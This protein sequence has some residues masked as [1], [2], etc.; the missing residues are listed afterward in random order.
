MTDAFLKFLDQN[1]EPFFA[2]MFYDASHQPYWYPPEHAVF[3]VGG[4]TEDINYLKLPHD[5]AGMAFIKNRYKNSLHYVDAELGRVLT[6]LQDRGLATNTLVFV[7]GDHGEEFRECGLFGHDSSFSPWQTKTLMVA[8]IPGE[9]P[10]KI[11]RLTSHLDVP[12][13][14][15]TYMGVENP[16]SD[17]TQGLPLTSTQDPPFV[18]VASWDTAAI[19]SHETTTMFGLEAYKIETTVFDQRYAPLPHQ[20]EALAAQKIALLE[21]LNGMRQFT[22]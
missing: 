9:P 5:A 17:Y 18:Y 22:R 13:T 6:A 7:M 14:I 11:S 4:V 12:P 20:R 19:V 15:L 21:A 8:R 16:L 1:H 2:F 10:R 3:D